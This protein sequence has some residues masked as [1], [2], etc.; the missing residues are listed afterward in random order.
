M[1]FLFHLRWE[2]THLTCEVWVCV[3]V[4]GHCTN[5]EELAL[6]LLV[7]TCFT[8]FSLVSKCAENEQ[9]PSEI[10]IW[11]VKQVSYARLKY[12]GNNEK[13]T[14]KQDSAKH[15]KCHFDQTLNFS[16]WTLCVCVCM[17]VA[18]TFCSYV[19]CLP[20]AWIRFIYLFFV[21]LFQSWF[22]WRWNENVRTIAYGYVFPYGLRCVWHVV[23]VLNRFPL[24][25]TYII[26]YIVLLVE[27]KRLFSFFSDLLKFSEWSSTATEHTNKCTLRN[28]RLPFHTAGTHYML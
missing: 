10:S 1:C 4:S 8:F 26:L 19:H 2:K 23:A 6:G 24:C 12:N 3:C 5:E 7:Q 28:R 17:Y 16:C 18:R 14:E 9:L 20:S 22:S 11:C 25:T 27:E 21:Y 13:T 15:I